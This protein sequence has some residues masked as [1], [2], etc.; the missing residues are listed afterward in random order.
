MA[1]LE[2]DAE[3]VIARRK[4][5]SA[6]RAA[7]RKG[8]SPSVFA[9][10]FGLG[11]PRDGSWCEDWGCGDQKLFVDER[12]GWFYL[13]YMHAWTHKQTGQRY[14]S[15]RVAR[16]RLA[17][18]MAPGKWAKWYRGAWKEPGLGSHDSDMFINAGNTTVSYNTYRRI[19]ECI[20][21]LRRC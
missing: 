20:R 7:S 18:R 12:Q 21:I 19:G 4:Q 11:S 5:R 17:D 10:S 16:C 3:L 1:S 14:Q 13:W 8:P 9:S 15:M 6:S 2:D